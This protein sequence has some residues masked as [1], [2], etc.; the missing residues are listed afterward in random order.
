MFVFRFS[1]DLGSFY[2]LLSARMPRPAAASSTILNVIAPGQSCRSNNPVSV[3]A[4]PALNKNAG[5]SVA[6]II[7]WPQ[8]CLNAGR[9]V[10]RVPNG[11]ED[12]FCI[13]VVAPPKDPVEFD[14]RGTTMVRNAEDG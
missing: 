14:A 2:R 7:E 6:Y 13:A 3:V 8:I 5:L 4:M 10:W 1:D 12:E 11:A 9:L